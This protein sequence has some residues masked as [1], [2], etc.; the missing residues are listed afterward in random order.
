MNLSFDQYERFIWLPEIL[1]YLGQDQ[2]KLSIL[3]VGGFPGHLRQVLPESVL[4]HYTDMLVPENDPHFVLMD[5][6]GKIPLPDESQDLVV[7]I[8]TRE[9]VHPESRES[10]L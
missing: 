10:F 6:Q 2:E 7:S 9:N 4:Y 8:D 5:E 1:K 3:D